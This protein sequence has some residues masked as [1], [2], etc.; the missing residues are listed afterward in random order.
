MVSG[1]AG[2]VK[3]EGGQA[4]LHARTGTLKVHLMKTY[5]PRSFFNTLH[6]P[7]AIAAQFSLLFQLLIALLCFRHPGQLPSWLYPW[8]SSTAPLDAYDIVLVDQLSAVVPWIRH[9]TATRV[10]FFCHYPYKEVG[11]SIAKQRAIARGDKGP[12]MM[13][14]VYRVPLDLF[15]EA[16]T[17]KSSRPSTSLEH[18]THAS[19]HSGSA[20]K[21][22]VNS[23]FT[24]RQF[25]KSFPRLR[26]VPRVVYPGV[27]VSLYEHERVKRNIDAL[28]E[29]GTSFCVQNGI[30][31]LCLN[32]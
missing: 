22:L 25:Q 28:G 32:T 2:R 16:T 21:I 14:A 12:G 20:D 4:D 26:R 9:L 23:H 3:M 13:R 10:V 6:L 27:D 24:Q 5:I 15:E 17:S 1:I 29:L 11:N 18:C 31:N 7:F 30:R 19:P 8:L